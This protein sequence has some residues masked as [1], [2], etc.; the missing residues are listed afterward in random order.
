M[1]RSL[2]FVILSVVATFGVAAPFMFDVNA[3]GKADAVTLGENQTLAVTV[4]D[5]TARYA[6]PFSATRVEAAGSW[7]VLAS[8]SRAHIV[9]WRDNKLLMAADMSIGLDPSG[10]WRDDVSVSGST[11]ARTRTAI[12]FRDCDEQLLTMSREVWDPRQRAFQFADHGSKPTNT[13]AALPTRSQ[14]L[15]PP[16]WLMPSFATRGLETMSAGQR[17]ALIDGDPATPYVSTNVSVLYYRSTQYRAA[18]IG[19]RATGPSTLTISS[20]DGTW[21]FAHAPGPPGHFTTAMLPSPQACLAISVPPHTKISDIF[22]LTADELGSPTPLAEAARRGDVYAGRAALLRGETGLVAIADQWQHATGDAERNSLVAALATIAPGHEMYSRINA[23]LA[24]WIASGQMPLEALAA[25]AARWKTQSD[26]PRVAAEVVTQPNAPVVAIEVLLPVA[27]LA[28][29]GGAVVASLIGHASLPVRLAA[30]RVV[31]TVPADAR[32]ALW[33]NATPLA[34]QTLLRAMGRARD[35]SDLPRLLAVTPADE[36]E[37][38]YLIEALAR[39]GSPEA[40]I[41]VRRHLA[42]LHDE[43]RD[44]AAEIVATELVA[45][46]ASSRALLTQLCADPHPDAQRRALTALGE[47]A[48]DQIAN[49]SLASPWPGV[50]QA[51]ADVWQ[52]KCARARDVKQGKALLQRGSDERDATTAKLLIQAGLR[53]GGASADTLAEMT[54]SGERGARLAAADALLAHVPF[55]EAAIHDAF[56]SARMD[57]VFDPFALNVAMALLPGFRSK[58]A[59]EALVSLYADEFVELAV[60]AIAITPRVGACA[61][62]RPRLADI[63]AS[64]DAPT[65]A[66]AKQALRECAH[67]RVQPS[68]P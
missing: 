27:A 42:A 33:P 24:A 11:I 61:A 1:L 46:D 5:N 14:A 29:N 39:V 16:V 2:V 25:V 4:N 52:T 60:A 22:V 12:A 58:A 6:I 48:S 30:G 13:G 36:R 18:A 7:I 21:H 53:C 31:Q 26:G 54:R 32:W 64:P 35:P 57:A 56:M 68:T 38:L 65:Q 10:T 59:H 51:A 17:S 50:R 67:Q 8:D 23:L 20:P 47:T 49:Q 3:D 43:A 15:H 9:E 41:A 45:N 28:P 66:A 63:A 62:G 19:L 44:H 55:A 34:R 40:V 37:A